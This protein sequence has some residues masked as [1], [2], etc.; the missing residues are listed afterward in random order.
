MSEPPLYSS[1]DGDEKVL[2]VFCKDDTD[3]PVLYGDKYT[4]E[5]ITFHHFCLVR[6]DRRKNIIAI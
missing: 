4:Y 3:D 1:F 6:K 2:C 5:S